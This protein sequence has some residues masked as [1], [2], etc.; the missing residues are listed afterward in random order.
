MQVQKTIKVDTFNN[1]CSVGLLASE[2]KIKQADRGGN[3]CMYVAN[4]KVGLSGNE[5]FYLKSK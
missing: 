4:I 2:G 5:Q 1:Y 3:E